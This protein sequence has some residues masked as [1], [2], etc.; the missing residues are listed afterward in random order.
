MKH[1]ISPSERYAQGPWQQDPAQLP[2]LAALDQRF[3]ALD[4]GNKVPGLYLWGDVGRGKTMLMDLFFNAVEG[5]PKLRLHF[6]HFMA[7]VHRDLNR[8]SGTREPL[9]QIAATLA[10]ECRLL[11]FDEFFVS[12]IGDAIILG[13]LLEGLFNRGVMLVSTSNTPIERLYE[14]GLQ[15]ERFLPTIDLLQQKMES[16]HLN[17]EQDHRLTKGAPHARAALPLLQLGNEPD[18][19][20]W[21]SKN[22]SGPGQLCIM[23]RALFFQAMEATQSLAWFRFDQL[24][25]GPRST[26]D[27]MELAETLDTLLLSHV[28]RLGGERRGW[29]RARGTEDAAEAVSTGDRKLRYAPEDDAARRFIALIDEFYDRGKQLVLHAQVPLE[30]LYQGGALSFEFRRTYSRLSEMLQRT[31]GKPRAGY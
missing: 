13:R 12:D 29:I 24:C 10:K 4:Q 5:Q 1:T 25:E 31:P 21:F 16:L 26:L 7:R 9:D 14:N 3:Q 8:I 27:Y 15:R 20:Q 30:Q 28:P 18:F 17:G 6:H 11:C 22:A 2:A 23:G 19:S